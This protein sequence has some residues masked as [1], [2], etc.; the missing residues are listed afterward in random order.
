[1]KEEPQ[2]S[3]AIAILETEMEKLKR[4]RNKALRDNEYQY[5]NGK[6]M[7]FVDAIITLRS[8]INPDLDAG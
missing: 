7:S 5:Y 1:M 8:W 2:I 6:I 3:L 4:Q